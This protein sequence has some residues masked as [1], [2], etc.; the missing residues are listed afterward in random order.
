MKRS[1]APRAL[2][3][4]VLCSSTVLGVPHDVPA[5]TVPYDVVY[6]R[7]PRYGDATNTT[8]PE[9]FHP[10][11]I[12]P[13]ADLMLLHPDGSEEVLV[14]GGNGSVTDPFVSFDAQWV[15]YAYFH[16]ARPQAW[17]YQ[18]GLF[19]G[20]ADVYRINLAT[21]QTQQ[22]TFGEFTPNTGAGN[23]DESNPVNPS[24]GH[25][26]LGYGILNL[27]PAP[28]AGGKIAF[29]SNRNGF[30]PPKGYTTPTLQLFVMD[31]DGSNVTQIAPMN[32]SSALH[33]TPLADGRILFSSHESQGLR[34]ARMWGV[35]A[36]WPDGRRWEPIVSAFHDGVPVL[37]RLRSAVPSRCTDRHMRAID[38]AQSESW[39]RSWARSEAAWRSPQRSCHG[40]TSRQKAA[41]W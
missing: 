30:A 26:Y 18:R 6:V 27:G 10:A 22:L 8:W 36:I 7:Q 16:D 4:L 35:W 17:N 39:R 41:S 25:D 11:Q 1:Q 29:T 34:D 13:G 12:D 14:P 21:R 38:L 33:P 23:F 32:V 9:V 20:G 2:L 15:Y 5:A 24:P 31:E 40:R 3:L 19:Y 28:L 37:W